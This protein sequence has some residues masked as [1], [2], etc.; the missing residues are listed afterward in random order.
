VNRTLKWIVSLMI[1]CVAVLATQRAEASHFRYGN[2][3]W[4]ITDP[5]NAPETVEFTVTHGWRSDFTDNIT[6]NFGDGAS[7]PTQQGANIGGGID[8]N[9]EPYTIFQFTVSHTYAAIPAGGSTYTAFFADCCRV[10]TLV[11]APNDN[12]RVE[13][14][15]FLEAD[16]S[17]TSG[18]I[19]GIPVI[20]QMPVGQ[21]SSFALPVFD[22]DA[23]PHT[24]AFS[25]Q[26]QSGIPTG[27]N[28]PSAGGN[29]LQFAGPGCTIQWDLTGVAA[30][31]KYATSIK[32]TSSNNGN[33][34]STMIDYIIELVPNNVAPSCTGSG[35][36]VA[37]VGQLFST[38]VNFTD[39]TNQLLDIST[40]G[41]PG[42]SIFAPGLPAANFVT[43]G[44]VSFSWTPTLADAGSSN[45]VFLVGTDPD[46]FFTF[47]SLIV[48][49]PQCPNF[50]NACTVGVGE[51]ANSGTLVCIGNMSVCSATP[52]TP[53]AEVCDGLD[54]NCDG[55]SD[56]GNPGGGANCTS[57]FPGVCAAGTTVC[58]SPSLDCVANITPGTQMEVCDTQDN[59][60][61]G[62]TD[63]GFNLGQSC[64]VGIGACQ[65]SGTTICDMM[66]GATC[67]A[68]P[69]PPGTEIC[70][71][72][73]DEDCDGVLN[74]GCPDTD[75]D[76]IIDDVEI[77][78]GSDPLDADTDDDGV[79]DGQEPTQGNCIDFPACFG[80]SDGDGLNSV[81]DA[82]S[83]NDGLLDGTE[84]GFDCSNPD[85]D[86]AICVPDADMGATTTDP[87]DADT[88]NGT[89]IDG[90]EDSNLDGAPNAGET[91]PTAGNGADDVNVTDTDGDGLSDDLEI[92]IGSD[93]NDAD[94]DDDGVPDGQEP[95]PTIDTDGD[96]LINI[97]DVDSDNDG[98]Y[99]GTEMG[100]DCNNPDTDPGPPS[101]CTPDGDDGG[102]TTSPL[103]ADT[104]NGGVNDGNEDAN[105][106]GVIDA[107]ETDPTA[108]NGAD[109]TDPTNIDT[110]GDGLS[111]AL[112][113]FIG[114]D[115]NDQDSDD[116][117][118]S[119]GEEPN[120]ADDNDGDGL[121]NA[122]DVDSDDDGLFD[123]TETGQDCS[124]PD[125]DTSL[126]NCVPDADQGATTTNPLL[127]DTDGGGV[128]D[129]AEDSNLDGAVDAGEL[130]PNE[131]SDDS[132]V[133]DTDG[134]GLSDDLEITLGSDPNDGDTDDDGLL[135]GEEHNPS[136][137]NDGDLLIN[138]LDVDSDDDGLY[139]GTEAGKDCSDP[140]TDPG[141]PPHCIPDA[142]PSTET[143]PLKK[144]SDGGGV[145]DGS[146]DANLNGAVDNGETDPTAGNGGDDNDPANLDS[147]MDG[148]SDALEI[149]IGSDPMDLD[150][151][152]DGLLD[153]DENNPADDADGDGTSNAADEDADGDGL[154]DGTEKGNDCNHPA[155]DSAA[156]NCI[157]DGDAGATTTNHLDPDTDN[158]GVPDGEEDQNGNGVVDTGEGDPN[159]PSDDSMFEC[160][161]DDDCTIE[162]QVCDTSI[163]ICVDGCKNDDDCPEEGEICLLTPGNEIGEC[164]PDGSGGGGAGGEGGTGGTGGSGQGG[165][166]AN[167]S[168]EVPGAVGGCGCHV[169][170][171]DED[172]P[173]LLVIAGLAVVGIRRRRRPRRRAA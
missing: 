86:P 9:G 4:T 18:P 108:G 141:P 94:T 59:D 103:L 109:D 105:L 13:S 142:D 31:T 57:A 26:A 84:M 24:C 98:L 110:D 51:C 172:A 78:I 111:D 92:F 6:L 42:G 65:S 69:L 64:T 166:G 79:P 116:D 14:D 139:D 153:G 40:S 23:D 145:M 85:T 91:D 12:F 1:A 52:G 21:I 53:S 143:S 19:S 72:N 73:V 106:N 126:G 146:E 22:P 41:A 38:T 171:G 112:E 56:E 17:N 157:E 33:D 20:I 138:I 129:G 167:T 50:G 27:S 104:D 134:D 66:G 127:K 71:N 82:D 61:D 164:G 74:N 120:F 36:F 76:G 63:E 2:I 162:T 170:G 16:G 5:V 169:P 117:G 96:G 35:T 55:N 160:F 77:L 102:T 87:L 151:D 30:G 154:F 122:L 113:I 37:N 75:G 70:A 93:P 150:S 83:D 135:D 7:A 155:T 44:N 114:T 28:P 119:D 158:G 173:W 152:D 121:I 25:T 88:D 46:D 123:G 15:V 115:P 68:T 67:S 131:A 90:S 3:T 29:S 32:V 58:N 133:V 62:N 107:G 163:N 168:T 136:G 124:N 125:T 11:N 156:G 132:N 10:G 165:S 54:N 140:D 130:D 81:L 101:H 159:D 49:V 34:S 80:D 99:D 100:L 137:N 97:L 43:P 161:D 39:P 45:L 128:S 149:T 60:C 47:C 148:L 144:D 95:N 118:L 89:V 8:S 147:D 48:T